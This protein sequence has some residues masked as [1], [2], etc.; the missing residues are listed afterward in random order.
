MILQL[1]NDIKDVLLILLGA[2]LSITTTWI[3]NKQLHKMNLKQLA[4]QNKLDASKTAISWLMDVRGKLVT[5]IWLIEHRDVLNT[6]TMEYAKEIGKQL[7]VL[8]QD[9]REYFNA[10]ELYYNFDD[11]VNRY[12][13]NAIA[14]QVLD[15]INRINEI[16]QFPENTDDKDIKQINEELLAVCMHLYD[17]TIEITEIIRQDNMRYMK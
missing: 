10:I 16:S 13:L 2:I 4:V 5:T 1:L 12:D 8:E 6:S 11:V 17:A 15:L 7:T 9:A 14:P 3:A